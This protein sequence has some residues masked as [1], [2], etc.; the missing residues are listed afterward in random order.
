[1]SVRLAALIVNYNSG[2][3]AE[4]CVA[5]LHAGWD[6]AGYAREDLD[7][8]VVDNASPAP[9]DEHLERL[10]AAGCVVV[11]SPDNLGY[12]GGMN[13]ALAQTDDA[14]C[15]GN[16][17]VAVLNPDLFF[18][19]GS[20]RALVEFTSARL[21]VG[22]VDPRAFVDPAC[23]LN[24]PRNLLPTLVDH[25]WMALS[26]LSPAICRAYSRHR[27]KKALPW[28]SAGEP[29]AAEMLSGCCMFLRRDVLRAEGMLLDDRFP[30][31]YEDTDLARRLSK[32]GL[33]LIHHGGAR[34]LHHWSRS[35]GLVGQ[36]ESE[37]LT[38][39]RVAQRAYF[40]KYYGG[41][42]WRWVKLV[43]ALIAKWPRKWYDRPMHDLE[44]LGVFHE[45]VEVALPRSCRF[46]VE[47]G[48]APNFLL[49][50]GLFG[51][52]DRWRCPDLTWAWFFQAR[53]FMRILDRDTG[54]LLGAWTFDKAEPGRSEPLQLEEV[55]PAADPERDAGLDPGREDTEAKA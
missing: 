53:Y 29:L 51:E 19:P 38:R 5:S 37:A 11:R 3:F 47:M 21:D 45:P 28:W 22:V 26:Q 10:E 34:V 18:L 4:A 17:L 20:V 36:G 23:E 52:G 44:P 16:D 27:L 15:A 54:E 9:Q 49:S 24:L 48:M 8:V 2:A 50:A 39:Y 30:L 1:M 32:R 40:K 7:V 42:G 46:L 6:E 35:T 43:N 13:L 31:Y 41:L 33:K 55:W 25:T 12:A 14:A